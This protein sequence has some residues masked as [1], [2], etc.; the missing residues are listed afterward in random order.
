[1]KTWIYATAGGMAAV[2]AVPAMATENKVRLD[3]LFAYSLSHFDADATGDDLD[4]ESNGSNL[5]LSVSTSAAGL[6][7]F[8]TYR[9]G[10]DRFNDGSANTED[11]DYVREFFGGVE[12]AFGRVSYGRQSTAYKQ[13]AQR[14]D[15]FYDTSAAGFNGLFANEGSSYGLSN[16]SNGFTSNSLRYD[17][18]AFSGLSG[19]VSGFINDNG[20]AEGNDGDD[21]GAG[22]SWNPG[23]SGLSLG[24]EY[25]K[26]EGPVVFGF[27]APGGEA[28]RAYGAYQW[29]GWNFG[30]S[31]EHIDI[32]G[33]SDPRQYSFASLSYGLTPKLRLA[34]AYGHAQDTPFDGDGYTVGGFYTLMPQLTGYVAARQVSLDSGNDTT[35]IATGLAYRFGLALN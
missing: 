23:E 3:G 6:T 32:D 11:E 16:L 14:V 27:P 35:T 18:P 12:G 24:L 13:A 30:A 7:A 9:R 25:L 22:L 10:F 31:Y 17:S 4:A 5:G 33:I 15:P 1:M 21:F 19:H 28:L 8:A 34:A 20:E 29:Q 2:M 26:A